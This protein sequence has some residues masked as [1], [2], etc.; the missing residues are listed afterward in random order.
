MPLRTRLL[1]I[2]E[3]REK[4]LGYVK[5][6]AS[7]SLDWDKLGPLVETSRDLI[8]PIV[9][10]DVRMRSTYDAFVASTKSEIDE[11]GPM[12]YRKFAEER[13]KFL[14]GK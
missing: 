13:S 14:L 12:S 3:L 10:T 6:I 7:E 4:Y 1:A 11:D 9:K 8:D 2:P 5:Q